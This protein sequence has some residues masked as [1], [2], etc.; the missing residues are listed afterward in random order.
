MLK[1]LCATLALVGLTSVPVAAQNA[2]LPTARTV[3]Q[4]ADANMGASKLNSVQYSATG[5]GST[6]GQKYS[7]TADDTWPR[8]DLKSYARTI[9]YPSMS[10]REEQVLVPGAWLPRGGFF[11]FTGEWRQTQFV[12]GNFAWDVASGRNAGKPV[13]SPSQSEARQ[14]D[15]MMTPHGFIRAALAAKDVKLS[16][17]SDGARKANVITFKAFDKY[18]VNGWINAD[19][20]V[21]KTQTW[22]PHPILGDMFVELS[23]KDSYKD[24]S[25]IKFP[26]GLHLSFGSP[27]HSGLDIDITDVKPNI[28][29]SVLQVP[30]EIRDAK[31]QSLGPMRSRLLAPGI[32]FLSHSDGRYNSMAVEF[33]DYAVVL[34]SAMDEGRGSAVISETKR[35]IPNKP[36]RY[37]VNTHHH[38]DHSGALRTFAAEGS[39][40]ITHRSNFNFYE[41]V[42]FDLRPRTLHKDLLSMAPRE[43]DYVLVDDNYKMTDG[44]QTMV[45]Y[46][47]DGLEHAEDML[48]AW[49][50]KAKLLF[51]AD[52]FA[53]GLPTEP[54][55]TDT[56]LLYNM[57]RVG[58]QPEIFACVHGDVYPAADFLKKMEI[59]SILTQGNGSNATAGQ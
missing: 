28:P 57:R 49:F 48:V 41:N 8:F 2:A 15:I 4:A 14:V 43:V 24:Y 58:I 59:T 55:P 12:S 18:T 20:V 26:S 16:Q 9:D 3:L 17:R 42:I 27:P 50:P 19:N 45:L 40:I 5:Y 35:L 1:T 32:W 29:D 31:I 11:E 51:Q 47:M 36:I 7:A 39:T 44:D 52:M 38:F 21:I 56:N 33:K 6:L 25:G 22:L 34:E 53:P 10:S 30:P 13:A 37:L 54:K 46:H 23:T